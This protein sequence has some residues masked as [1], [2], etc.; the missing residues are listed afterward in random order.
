MEIDDYLYDLTYFWFSR[1]KD[2]AE[3]FARIPK[4]AHRF[5]DFG[6]GIGDFGLTVLENFPGAN[7]VFHDINRPNLGYL[8]W[9]L[10]Q[11]KDII[12]GNGSAYR[13]SHSEERLEKIL[14]ET[15][16][17][18]FHVVFCLD[19]LEHMSEPVKKLA[20]IRTLLE[21]NGL[22]FASVGPQQANQ[23]AH[24]SSLEIDKHGFIQL[25]M[26]LYIRDDSDMAVKMKGLKV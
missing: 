16:L 15:K 24:I 10:E 14:Q 1:R 9:R 2:A 4:D 17:A 20:Y 8:N 12:A 13:I 25:G 23:A 21:R 22:L 3:L 19:V 18:P 5:L 7:V 6:C 11:R 26:N